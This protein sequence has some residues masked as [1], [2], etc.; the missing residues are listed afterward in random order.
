MK[1]EQE[2]TSIK[3]VSEKVNLFAKELNLNVSGCTRLACHNQIN[4]ENAFK[5]VVEHVP[6]CHLCPA[7]VTHGIQ[8]NEQRKDTLT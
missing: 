8:F 6:R 4:L 2:T 1:L 7:K 5:D 3:R